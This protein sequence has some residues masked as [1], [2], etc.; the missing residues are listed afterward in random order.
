MLDTC[1][2]KESAGTLAKMFYISARERNENGLTIAMFRVYKHC[3]CNAN[4]PTLI[5]KDRFV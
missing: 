4:V 5:G 2:V 3:N 1:P